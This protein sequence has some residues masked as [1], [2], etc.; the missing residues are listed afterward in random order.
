[1]IKTVGLAECEVFHV[2]A[3]TGL[4]A[5]GAGV[6]GWGSAGPVCDSTERVHA[7]AES[8]GHIWQE[9]R[10]EPGRWGVHSS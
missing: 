9:G 7:V 6:S 4:D 2:G 1:M 5:A 3:S 10:D 8:A